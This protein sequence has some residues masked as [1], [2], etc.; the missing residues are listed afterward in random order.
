MRRSHRLVHRAVWPVLALMVALGLGAAL[1]L[2]PPPP[3]APA[4]AETGRR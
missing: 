3:G 4:A 2:R 1:W